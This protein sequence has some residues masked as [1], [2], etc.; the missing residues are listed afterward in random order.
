M[1]NFYRD[2]S[3]IEFL[4]KHMALGE[5]ARIREK[6]FVFA[7][8]F[9]YAPANADDALENYDMVLDSLGE[10]SGDFIAP[11]AED[12]DRQGNTLNADGTVTRPKGVD[13]SLVKL[14][15]QVFHLPYLVVVVEY[16]QHRFLYQVINNLFFLFKFLLSG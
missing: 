16:F 2:N 4:F 5:V 12:V 10:L 14:G 6:G 1:A 11:R 9:D 8:E 3:D 13:E 7:D 15:N